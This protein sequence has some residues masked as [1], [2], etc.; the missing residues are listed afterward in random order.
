MCEGRTTSH[1]PGE[2]VWTGESEMA[3][4]LVLLAG[5]LLVDPPSPSQA[6]SLEPGSA[7]QT[8]AAAGLGRHFRAL[9]RPFS[10][11][12]TQSSSFYFL[13]KPMGYTG[14]VHLIDGLIPPFPLRTIK[15]LTEEGMSHS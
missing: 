10:L 6:P 7:S 3:W 4:D 14:F 1:L 2:S 5:H 15:C 9:W 11:I 8:E 12:T 13:N